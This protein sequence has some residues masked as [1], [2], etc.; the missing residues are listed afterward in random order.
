MLAERHRSENGFTSIQFLLASAL[1]LVFFTALANL[2]VVQFAAGAVRSALDQGVRAGSITRSAESCE[3]RVVEVLDG[4]LGGSVGDTKTI[5]CEIV[6]FLVVAEGS[7]A[8]D[9]WT[10]F[11]R[12]F[13]IEHTAEARLEPDAG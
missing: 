12:D 11:T 5:N 13:L 8:V 4:L 10:P 2:V 9:S 3:V 6:G 7:V 1:A